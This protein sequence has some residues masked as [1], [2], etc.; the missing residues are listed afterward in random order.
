MSAN[1]A[2]SASST[3]EGP[4]ARVSASTAAGVVADDVAGA[5]LV[6]PIW[7]LL[8]G[9]SRESGHWGAFPAHLSDAL[10]GLRRDTQVLLLDLPGTGANRRQ[11]SPTQVAA[12]VD[13][14][15]R[16]LVRRGVVGPV[17]LVG[18]SLGAMVLTDWATRYP[19]EVQAG[20]LIN[21][22]LQPFSQ[23][24]RKSRPMSYLG[25]L[26]LSLSRFSARMREERV[27]RLTTRMTPKAEV[28]DRW[29]ELQR[30]HPLGVRNT[31]RQWLASSRFKASRTCPAAPILLL[32]SKSDHLVDW[33]CSQAISRAWGAPLR[34]HTHAGH[35]LPLDDPIWVARAVADWL[36]DRT[37]QR[38]SASVWT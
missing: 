3:S 4:A 25:L 27:L 34:L 16:E 6:T 22:S 11:A 18:M 5:E 14:C 13:L 28:L 12:I 37:V 9:L 7:V 17:S 24:F 10:Q 36:R 29:M 19:A 38:M 23:M 32:C 8:R 21:A 1:P 30:Q 31:V 26:L 20:V 35:D 33:R 15:R 2:F